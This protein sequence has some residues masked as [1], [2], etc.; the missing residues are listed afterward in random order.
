ME[1]VEGLLETP[2]DVAG[3][4]GVIEGVDEGGGDDGVALLI[5][6]FE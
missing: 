2:E 5:K 3:D 1:P 6:L 4:G